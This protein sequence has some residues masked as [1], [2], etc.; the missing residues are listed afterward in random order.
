MKSLFLITLAAALLIGCA[1]LGFSL[2]DNSKCGDLAGTWIDSSDPK[3]RLDINP[4]FTEDRGYLCAFTFK[5]KIKTIKYER[6]LSGRCYADESSGIPKRADG[7]ELGGDDFT[8]TKIDL[9]KGTLI[10]RA[11]ASEDYLELYR[12]RQTTPPSVELYADI[13]NK[14][15]NP[16]AVK[17]A[18]TEDGRPVPNAK[19]KVHLFN[20]PDNDKK[21]ADYFLASS[22]INP[23]DS[24]NLN[25]KT[26]YTV[27][28]YQVGLNPQ[29]PLKELKNPLE[30]VTDAYGR[31]S[32]EAFLPLGQTDAILPSRNSPISI[33]VIVE[34]S[35]T[36]PSGNDKK[37]AETRIDDIE[38]EGIAKVDFIEYKEPAKPGPNG[39]SIQTSGLL[40]D[41]NDD[42]GVL[43]GN[44]KVFRSDRVVLQPA[45][46]SA[47]RTLK[48]GDILSPGDQITINTGGLLPEFEE[49]AFRRK[50]GEIALTLHFFD[51][52]V[53]KVIVPG[54][55]LS[56]HTVEIGKSAE[57]SGWSIPIVSILTK[58]GAKYVVKNLFSASGHIFTAQKVFG[59]LNYVAGDRPIYIQ[60]KSSIVTDFD[61]QGRML[62][63][64]REGEATI[65][66]DP[67]AKEGLAVPAGKTAVVP[68]NQ[69]PFL[70]D[71]DPD[72]AR[73]ADELLT[74]V[75]DPLSSSP[76][77]AEPGTASG[78]T[79]LGTN[80]TATGSDATG[81]PNAGNATAGNATSGTSASGGPITPGV[82]GP[83]VS[84]GGISS[85]SGNNQI[86]DTAQVSV[87]Q[88][89]SQ[90]ISP[91]GS[92]NF[93]GFKAD[94]SGIFKMK[95]E[96]VPKDMKPY[97]SMYDK[98]MAS[99]SDKSASN[100]GDTLSLE[101]DVQ[102]PG[103][104][105][106]EVKD[107][108]GKAYSQP[109]TLKVDFEPAPDQY[110]P[111]PNF[112][113]AAEV[114]S[115]DAINAY[116]CPSGDEDIYRINADASGIL[117]LN[118]DSVPEDMKAGLQLYDKGFGNEIAYS[119]ASNPGDKVKLEK[120]VHGPGWFFIKVRDDDG[121]AYSQPYT[122]NVDFE[123]APDQY[124][125]NPNFFRATQIATGQSITAYICPSGDEDFYKFY[126]G[127]S[128]IVKLNLD[129]VPE[130]MKAGLQLYDKS[131]G[132][133]IAYSQASNP[134]DKVKLEKDVQGP[135]WFYIKVRDSDGKA[136]SQ[137]YTLTASF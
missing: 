119:Q 43:V 41:W 19:L 96:N 115:G 28:Q 123:P 47:K 106:I 23:G 65:L 69:T 51:G 59:V 94:S 83:G 54:T 120:D 127:P 128:G 80:G 135:G 79:P 126:M 97:L 72:T 29:C 99:I 125:P 89:I 20:L 87:G 136:H 71:T 109:Y 9:S 46:G 58:A 91:A 103:W 33:P 26:I 18:L 93:Y 52:F 27:C 37:I 57:E 60:V 84:T 48:S 34:Y 85:P 129:N 82:S 122:L 55:D 112:F 16:L 7:S 17:I 68:K 133:E 132:N 137:P 95:L 53:G 50:S 104:F 32:M 64:T 73:E 105:Y 25:G 118:M 15:D 100:P 74:G 110:E 130:N 70:V 5:G 35:E 77:F 124:E 14:V 76:V 86:G 81:I 88:S 10:Y 39:G 108:Q 56:T 4:E 131:F 98:N 78:G 36:D 134:G 6:D 8:I 2:C 1:P 117:K 3:V 38:L 66:T 45:D 121:R 13:P 113:R 62:V 101:K 49:G 63:T 22:C 102:G 44:A 42:P 11:K 40:K 116:I 21:L 24:A 75:P 92:S 111:N 67:T 30:I 12:V 90:T 114:R 107:A 31:A 61:D